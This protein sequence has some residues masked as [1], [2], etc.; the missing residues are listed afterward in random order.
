[1]GR[2]VPAAPQPGRRRRPVGED[3]HLQL[4]GEPGHRPP[5]QP[6]PVQA[7]QGAHGR[8]RR[9]QRRL[10]GSGAGPPAVGDELSTA[11]WRTL[12][13]G[14]ADRLGSELDA[15]R[16][17]ERAAGADGPE[18][19]AVLDEAASAPSVAFF[20]AM[21][22]RRRGGEPLQY[23][24]GRWAFR[25]LEL[26]VDPRVLIPRPETEQVVEVA[27]AELARLGGGRPAR[28]MTA[29]DLGTGSGAIALSLGA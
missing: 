3:T 29:A 20:D 18:L 23:V 27:L 24:V 15:R 16:I 19:F 2:A 11:T 9:A 28:A 1:V 13:A 26:L 7:G 8:A 14:A 5:H 17:G 22:E 25:T 21:V 4:Q 10:G 6:D 12:L